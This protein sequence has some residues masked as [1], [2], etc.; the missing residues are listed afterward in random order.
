M[1][2]KMVKG[3]L[4]PLGLDLG[5]TAVRL[6]QFRQHEGNYDMIAAASADILA[7]KQ[8]DFLGDQAA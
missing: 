4:L 1:A 2:V 3:K 8:A 6:A 7:E 5:T